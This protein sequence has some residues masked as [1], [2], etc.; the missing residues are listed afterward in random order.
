MA[1]DSADHESKL[2]ATNETDD[3]A[4]G[5]VDHRRWLTWGVIMLVASAIL[6]FAV[7]NQDVGRAIASMCG[8]E[9]G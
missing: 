3:L 2:A 8:F 6:P 4:D 7:R 9:L 1:A 5:G